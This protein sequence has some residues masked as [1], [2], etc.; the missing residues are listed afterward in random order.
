MLD[1]KGASVNVEATEDCLIYYLSD[2][3]FEEIKILF[4]EIAIL[5]AKKIAKQICY[6]VRL[7]VKKGVSKYLSEFASVHIKS[8]NKRFSHE[9]KP[10]IASNMHLIRDFSLYKELETDE[11]TELLKYAKWL[12]IPKGKIIYNQGDTYNGKIYLIVKG[13]VESML[14]YGKTKAKLNVVGPGDIFGHLEFMDLG[15]R[16]NTVFA[17][18]DLLLLSFSADKI[19]KLK[20]KD[21]ILYDKFLEFIIMNLG[22]LLRSTN[23]LS[24]RILAIQQY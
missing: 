16:Y 10:D 8:T 14:T 1:K 19:D 3:R 2:I 18:E 21:L 9:M 15:N 12:K 4:P 11:F 20:H 13:A 22:I 7:F 6:K 17:R 5:L 24:M 23:K